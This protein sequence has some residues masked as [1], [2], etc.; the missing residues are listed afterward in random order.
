M[1]AKLKFSDIEASKRVHVFRFV[2]DILTVDILPEEYSYARDLK[3]GEA[4][5]TYEGGDVYVAAY[6][7]CFNR[8]RSGKVIPTWRCECVHPAPYPGFELQDGWTPKEVGRLFSVGGADIVKRV[9]FVNQR[10]GEIRHEF[11]NSALR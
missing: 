6:R 10:I 11:I 7:D 4:F 2:G 8:D 5:L 1:N 9:P 3:V